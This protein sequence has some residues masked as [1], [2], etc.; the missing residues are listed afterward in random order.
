MTRATTTVTIP[1]IQ[2]HECRTPLNTPLIRVREREQDDFADLI[3]PQVS[4]QL[5]INGIRIIISCEELFSGQMRPRLF[6]IRGFVDQN[7]YSN[8]FVRLEFLNS[9]SGMFSLRSGVTTA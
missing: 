5:I 7:D 4:F 3:A 2:Q 8:R 6:F 1:G 9:A